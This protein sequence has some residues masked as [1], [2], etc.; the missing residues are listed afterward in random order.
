M[1]IHGKRF[2]KVVL[3]GGVCSLSGCASIGPVYTATSPVRASITVEMEAPPEV[4]GIL[5]YRPEGAMSGAACSAGS[6]Q[7]IGVLRNRGHIRNYA[8]R[9]RYVESLTFDIDANGKP[10]R[11]VGLSNE[12][13][14]LSFGYQISGKLRI[15]QPNVEFV[16]VPGEHYHTRF[17]ANANKCKMEVRTVENTP[18]PGYKAL[19]SCYIAGGQLPSYEAG[20]KEEMAKNPVPYE[21]AARETY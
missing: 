19:P 10:F 9:G 15:C 12:I 2:R 14:N 17:F 6:M 1:A 4:E 11:I 3:I 21:A 13:S 8:D 16:P 5:L 18:A 20:L 7:P